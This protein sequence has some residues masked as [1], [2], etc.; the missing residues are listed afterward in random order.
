MCILAY[1]LDANG[2]SP[3]WRHAPQI[4]S[5]G[6]IGSE[7]Q[8]PSIGRPDHA[9]D[10]PVVESELAGNATAA[11][12][13]KQFCRLINASNKGHD[14]IVRRERRIEVPARA[15]GGR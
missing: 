10:A 5:A 15:G 14:A 4:V 13:Y 6:P 2:R 1:A 11:R 7:N 9:I 8:L 3:I 12:H